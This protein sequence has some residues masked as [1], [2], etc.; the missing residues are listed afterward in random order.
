MTTK[1][2]NKKTAIANKMTVRE[3][4]TWLDGYCSAHTEDWTPSQEQWK[5]I[6]NKIFELIET[7]SSKQSASFTQPQYIPP[8]TQLLP[9][10]MFS[11][12]NPT[13]QQPQPLPSSR[14]AFAHS[15]SGALKTPDGVMS[16]GNSEFT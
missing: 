14:P 1:R 15:T 13:P 8:S 10:P 6:K 11:G 12:N 7:D 16:G 5:I 4:K 2:Q 3:L 9:A